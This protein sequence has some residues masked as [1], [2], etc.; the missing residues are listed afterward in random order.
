[1]PRFL[2]KD[3][4]GAGDAGADAGLEVTPDPG[5]DL[6]RAAVGL[7]ALEVEPEALGAP[8]EVRVVDVAAIGVERVDH[9]EEVALQAGGLGSGVQGR[10]AL[11]L[12]GDREVAED[13]GRLAFADLCPGCG[14]VRTAEVR[15]DDQL[16]SLSPAMVLRP[17]RRD[18]GAG[19]LRRQG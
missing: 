6:V 15:I 14:T 16:R 10:G 12:A 17:D 5:G 13:D 4:W 18:R 8:P 3:G 2:G 11:M 1:M 19:Q 7:E 9:L